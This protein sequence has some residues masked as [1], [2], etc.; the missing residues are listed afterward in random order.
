MR[1]GMAIGAPQFIS[2]VAASRRIGT[3][4][5]RRFSVSAIALAFA[6]AALGGCAGVSSFTA[7]F[8]ATDIEA[9][10]LVQPP[11]P[12][13]LIAQ[14]K[15][16]VGEV[17]AAAKPERLASWR[18][19]RGAKKFEGPQIPFF[20]ESELGRAYLRSGPGRALARGEP[21]ESCPMFGAALD[22]ASTEAAANI[23]LERCLARRVKADTECGCRLLAADTVLFAPADN[24]TYARAVAATLIPLGPDLAS[25]GP[26]AALIAEERY[27]P[28]N[29]ARVPA[30]TDPLKKKSGLTPARAEALASGERRLWLIGLQGPVAGLDLSADGAARLTLLEGPREGMKPIKE[31]NGRWSADGFRRGRLAE[32]VALRSEK[33]SRMLLLIG[34]E[35]QE[36]AEERPRLLREGRKLF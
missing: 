27:T 25:A 10:R 22:A 34:Y 12:P 20:F 31:F 1:G 16:D 7:P 2:N 18:Q 19:M 23:A 9:A 29:A 30:E 36:L 13:K 14:S 26:E 35:P 5:A 6:A 17:A 11:L 28:L 8:E 4:A 21:A 15:R 3:A 32:R 24:F 33:G